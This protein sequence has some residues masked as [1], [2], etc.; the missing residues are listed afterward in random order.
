V[1]LT[2]GLGTPA[3]LEPTHELDAVHVALLVET[4]RCEN[5][6]SGVAREALT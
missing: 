2:R 6:D 5:S 3:D 4:S 1:D